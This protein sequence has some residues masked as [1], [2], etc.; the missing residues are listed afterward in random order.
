MTQPDISSVLAGLLNTTAWSRRCVLP[1][2]QRIFF[3]TSMSWNS[4]RTHN[5]QESYGELDTSRRKLWRQSTQHEVPNPSLK[6]SK[7][8]L[9]TS[10][11][12]DALCRNE[13]LCRLLGHM[14]H[15]Q[16][17]KVGNI[18]GRWGTIKTTIVHRPN[19]IRHKET[20]T[21]ERVHRDRGGSR[22]LCHSRLQKCLSMH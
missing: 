15:Q 3:G 18:N 2:F 14:Q 16:K 19:T 1:F 13:D 9:H 10:I 17:N 4:W 8:M 12:I 11:H 22:Q 21:N 5:Q 6:P 7:T 20:A